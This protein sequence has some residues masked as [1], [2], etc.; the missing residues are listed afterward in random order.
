MQGTS[1]SCPFVS[2]VVALWLQADNNLGYSDV[3][4]VINA[5]S[6][7]DRY[8]TDGGNAERWGAGKVDALAGI[9]YILDRKA[10]IGAVV[11]DEP[12]KMVFVSPTANGYDITVA[13]ASEV[14]ATLYSVS[15][16]VAAR[17][18]ASGSNAVISTAGLQSGVYVLSVDTPAGRHTTKLAVK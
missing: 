6:V 4:D 16:V 2:G 13:G 9:K 10:A 18:N 12:E 17:V 15:G 5:T 14:N 7:K 8:V 11:A 3:M 1:M